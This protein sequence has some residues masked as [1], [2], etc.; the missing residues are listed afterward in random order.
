MRTIFIIV[1]ML[2][3][4]TGPHE[5]CAQTYTPVAVTGFNNDV[6]AETGTSATAVTSCVL[7]L[8]NYILYTAAFAAANGIA[9]GVPNNGAIINGVRNYQLADYAGNNGLF[10]SQNGAVANTAAAGTLTL[11]TPASFNKISLLLFSTEGAST[12]SATL[13]FTDGTTAAGGAMTVQDWFGGGN[14][15]AS[16]FG[17]IARAAA[18]PY[19]VDGFTTSNPRFYRF[20]ISLSCV[21]QSKQL[22]SVTVNFL[23]GGTTFPSRA[24]IMAVSGIPATPLDITAVVTPAICGGADGGIALTV[25]GGIQ[26]LSYSWN[27][28]PVQTQP[29]ATNLPGGAYA[30]T[31]VDAVGCTTVFRDTVPLQSQGNLTVS[32]SEDSICAGAAVTLTAA[33]TGATITD[34]SWQPLNTSGAT[35]TTTPAASTTYIVTAQDAFGC[36]LTD[37]VAVAVKPLPAAAFTV[38]PAAVC[39]GTVQTITYTGTA[40]P[41]ASYNWNNFSGAAVQSGTGAGPYNILFSTA[42]NYSLELQVTDQG[43]V[44]AAAT[45]ALTVTA[46]PVVGF[47]VSDLTPCAGTATIISFTGNVS[48]A[49]TAAWDWGGGTVQRGSGL[50]PFD[51]VYTNSGAI[52]LTVTDGACIVTATPRQVTV[53][54]VP[55]A[56]FSPD[57]TVGCPDLPVVFTNQSQNAD[58]WFW[59]FGDSDLSS[60]QNPAHTYTVPGA[61][62]VTLVAGAQQQ[63]FDTLVETALINVQPS[64]VAAFT[65]IPGLDTE[66][67]FSEALFS[68]SNQSSGATAYNW[69]FGEGN[70]ATEAN[71]QHRYGLPGDYR[72]TLQITSEIGCTDTTSRAWLKIIPDKVLHIPNA[73]SPNGDGINDRWEIAGLQGIPGCHVEIFN[74]W[75]QRIYESIGYAHPWDG[76]WQGHLL[77][78]GT[79]YYVIKA[80]AKDK[81]YAGWVALL[82]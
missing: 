82:R 1:L 21:N 11:V 27:T 32:S 15:V 76:T 29:T 58:S 12:I 71:P 43:C 62:T 22:Q 65:V 47:E 23:S 41:T 36:K 5:L 46:A 73:F 26:P 75:G 50:G 57:V 51:V 14:A 79:Y 59:R 35:V 81:P 42:G 49:A 6:V 17:R 56:A 39:L 2:V 60:E 69:D 48:N 19:L 66:L 25:N 30:C 34:Y 24:V 64:P 4:M 54:P 3:C 72:V 74:R 70:S 37:S 38:T 63:C 53:I 77:P 67:E 9:G 68:F 80:K 7:D 40:G 10:L 33:V 52:N 31:I 45:R 55:L 18:G 28:T 20:D 13:N 8:S 16:G 78:L 44:S 61:Y